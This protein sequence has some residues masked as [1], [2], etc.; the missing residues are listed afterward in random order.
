MR[1]SLRAGKGHGMS[2]ATR[3]MSRPG[4]SWLAIWAAGCLAAPPLSS[5][6]GAGPLSEADGRSSR[7]VPARPVN[8]GDLVKVIH[9]ARDSRTGSVGRAVT[10]GAVGEMISVESMESLGA[11]MEALVVGERT[12]AAVR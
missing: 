4:L 7:A 8:P 1:R 12:V 6:P 5:G 2:V 3:S 11:T 9:T 10:G